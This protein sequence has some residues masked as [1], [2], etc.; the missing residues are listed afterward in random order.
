MSDHWPKIWGSNEE[1][2]HND[3]CSVNI[4][5]I[6]KGGVCSLHK[7]TAKSNLFYVLSGKL[8]LHTEIGDAVIEAG[9]NFTILPGT[10]HYF[11][12][13]EETRAIEVMSVKYDANDIQRDNVGHLETDENQET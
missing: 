6:R 7:H 9:Q 11:K 5:R 8:L 1:I 13:L 10:K 3:L 4:L 2:F 12:G